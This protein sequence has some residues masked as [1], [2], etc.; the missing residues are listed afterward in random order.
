MTA[1]EPVAL[2]GACPCR[3]FSV[4]AEFSPPTVAKLTRPKITADAAVN[5]E[6]FDA[7]MAANLKELRYGG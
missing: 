1:R 5:A 7:T 3:A 4:P 2:A 6:Q